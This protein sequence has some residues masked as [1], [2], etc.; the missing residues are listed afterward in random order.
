M[1]DRLYT[2]SNI[3]VRPSL[4][5]LDRV[6]IFE[7]WDNKFDLAL[8]YSVRRPTSD[9]VLLCLTSGEI[10]KSLKRIFRFEKW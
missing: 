6:F 2:W 4:V 9:H 5:K 1:I 3:R 10:T 8:A 7:E